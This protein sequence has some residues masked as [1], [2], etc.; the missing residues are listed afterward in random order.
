[1]K[2]CPYYAQSITQNLIEVNILLTYTTI[3]WDDIF[4]MS[5]LQ[6]VI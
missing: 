5:G 6:F 1:M 2:M 3:V 4:S